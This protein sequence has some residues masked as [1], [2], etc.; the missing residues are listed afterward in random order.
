MHST[1]DPFYGLPDAVRL[2]VA[3]RDLER[4]GQQRHHG[5]QC[6]PGP[7]AGKHCQRHLLRHVV[8]VAAQPG[9][10]GHQ[11]GQNRGQRACSFAS[12]QG[13]PWQ[14][15]VCDAPQRDGCTIRQRAVRILASLVVE[16]P[17][18]LLPFP[19]ASARIL[20]LLWWSWPIAC[21]LSTLPLPPPPPPPP[22]AVAVINH[23]SWQ[24][25]S[26]CDAKFDD[27]QRFTPLSEAC[28]TRLR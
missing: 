28:L 6:D 17:Y 2:P 18:R 1:H 24:S 22:R 7:L 9:V 13:D 3:L 23:R 26:A 12:L 16:L 11:P 21:C 20:L 8:H 15:I 14:R 25:C 4:E 27:S 10:P 5:N 19:S